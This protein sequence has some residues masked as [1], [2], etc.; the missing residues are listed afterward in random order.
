MHPLNSSNFGTSGIGVSFY[1]GTSVVSGYIVKQTGTNSFI[2]TDG[3]ITKQA[4]LAPTAAIA[5]ALSST[6]NQGYCTIQVSPNASGATGGSFTAHYAVQS[7][8][9]NS[10]TGTHWNVGD[11]LALPS[12]AGALTVASLSGGK[13]ATVTIGTAGN[14]TSLFSTPTTGTR[15]AGSGATITAH[16]GVDSAVIAAGGASSAAGYAMNDVLTLTGTGSATITVNSVDGGGG[17]LTFTVSAPGTVTSLPGNPVATS[18]GTGTGATFTLKYKLVALTTSGGTGYN[19]G[20]T[21]IFTGITATTAPTAS[22]LTV[23][24]GPPGA[25]ATFSLT[26]GSGITVKASSITTSTTTATFTLGYDLLSVSSSGGSGYA[27]NDELSFPGMTA[28]LLPTAH[29]ST[30]TTGAAT[31]TTVDTAGTDITVAASSIGVGAAIQYVAR[32]WDTKL[33]TCEGN[34]YFWSLTGA[35]GS[36]LVLGY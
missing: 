11:S 30:A 35:N 23:T 1:N 15:A 4:T 17:I 26:A 28:T 8:L 34:E 33:Y 21:L 6:G 5:T 19:I 16:Y 22:V 32:I 10:S 13:I 7:A 9:V 20:D 29:I 25:P 31:A 14:Y 12:G 36:A 3:T 24:G 27:V 18:G 2:V